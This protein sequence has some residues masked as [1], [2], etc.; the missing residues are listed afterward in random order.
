[1]RRAHTAY[2]DSRPGAIS[3]AARWKADSGISGRRSWCLGPSRKRQQWFLWVGGDNGVWRWKGTNLVQFTTADGLPQAQVEA[4]LVARD[5]TLWCGTLAGA[6]HYDGACWQTLDS[7]DGLAGNQQVLAIAEDASGAL[8]FGCKDGVSHYRPNKMPPTCRIVAVQ[9]DQEFT[10]VEALPKFVTGT[11]LTIKFDSRDFKTVPEKRLYRCRMGPGIT[12]AP[13]LDAPGSDMGPWLQ[14]SR[15]T[16]RDSPPVCQGRR[17]GERPKNR[18]RAGSQSLFRS[19]Q[20][21]QCGSGV[22]VLRRIRVKEQVI[23]RATKD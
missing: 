13:Q 15:G 12:A 7:R 1:M 3:C 14:A 4:L 6:A 9:T 10:N 5:G 11:R 23:F 18:S 20:A 16:D 2:A 19:G 22:S 21:L 17:P 8:W